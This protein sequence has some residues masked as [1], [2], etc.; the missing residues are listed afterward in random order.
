[1]C[2]RP[3]PFAP[4]FAVAILVSMSLLG[5][6]GAGSADASRLPNAPLVTLCYPEDDGT[7]LTN[8]SVRFIAYAEDLDGAVVN[9]NWSVARDGL[10]W[11]GNASGGPEYE[12]S[13]PE[14]GDYVITVTATDDEGLDGSSSIG[15]SIVSTANLP[16][17]P[18]INSPAD[19][20]TLYD[21][22]T[23]TAFNASGSYDPDGEIARYS[24][25]FPESGRMSTSSSQDICEVH[26]DTA[27]QYTVILTV[28][29]SMGLRNWTA[30]RLN[31]VYSGNNT[32]PVPVISAPENFETFPVNS[33]VSF[34]SGGSY[35][36]DGS[37]V[38]WLWGFQVQYDD[39]G[40]N[41]TMSTNPNCSYT[42]T[43]EGFYQV[44]LE[45]T[46]DHGKM[47]RAEM[48]LDIWGEE[49]LRTAN[50]SFPT[51][52]SA[53][54]AGEEVQFFA[55]G[56]DDGGQRSIDLEWDFG[57]GSPVYSGNWWEGSGPAARHAYSLPGEYTVA[58]TA[59][60]IDGKTASATR[61]IRVLSRPAMNATITA[62]AGGQ[63]FLVNESVTFMAE[64]HPD[65]GSPNLSF[66]WDFGDGATGDGP[67]VSHA[68]SNAGNY[69][70][71]LVVTAGAR[72][73]TA[74]LKLIIDDAAPPNRPPVAC[75]GVNDT[76]QR[77][78]FP[79]G[80]TIRFS[81]IGSYDPD[82]QSLT[83]D[84]DL[85]GASIGNGIEV[86]H[87]FDVPGNYTITLTVSDGE[88]SAT[89]N[90]MICIYEP[91]QP[92]ITVPG[93]QRNVTVAGGIVTVMDGRG[94]LLEGVVSEGPFPLIHSWDFGDGTTA[95]ARSVSHVYSRPGTYLLN[96]TVSDG[97][98]NWTVS[99]V[100]NVKASPP[101]AVEDAPYASYALAGVMILMLVGSVIFLGGTEIG[102]GLL[103]PLFVFLYSKIGRDEILDN[104]FRGRI[105]GYIVAN[106]GDHYTAIR[107]ALR[108]SNGNLA[109]H[110]KKLE[111]EG[112]IK[113][114]V[115]GTCRRYYPA[116][117]RVPEPNGGSLTQVQTM[118]FDKILET[119]GISQKDIA[120]ILNISAQTVGYHVDALLAKGVIRKQR[121]GMRVRL[122]A[123]EA[124]FTDLEGHGG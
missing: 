114:R 29:D 89:A 67:A 48:I 73:A 72:Q 7:Y 36:P 23:W 32:P 112:V 2:E 16:P 49:P 106:P 55:N 58:L 5:I 62:P 83:Y 71:R 90:L 33:T 4:V 102:L 122:F 110:L 100:V 123:D 93:G 118:V 88:L 45:V 52:D 39:Y 81:S 97:H 34:D 63:R 70:V 78:A 47:R 20:S 51:H 109:F 98:S 64:A 11:G 50:I 25:F 74:Q 75:I 42:F 12:E 94:M 91:P 27:G 115:D 53:L 79:A 43:R 9:Y 24:W 3:P 103:A 117:M 59:R 66:M 60:Y 37:I 41:T 77:R 92:K 95:S 105:S 85:S 120:G 26:V 104:F 101:R 119:P 57:D 107:E 69:S 38:S 22:S 10:Y 46:D 31:V 68:Y 121:A 14:K 17:V 65:T 113:S 28:C 35:D 96:Y 61:G 56:T 87:A 54:Y 124:S 13:F 86:S 82:G 6:L 1:M 15:F 40:Y 19:N 21:G 80:D 44:R 18:V 8:A 111:Q 76:A 99:M 116:E 84:W 30:S 108:L